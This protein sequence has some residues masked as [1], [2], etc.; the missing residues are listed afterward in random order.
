M[1]VRKSDFDVDYSSDF[2]RNVVLYHNDRSNIAGKT[3]Y[4]A[5]DGVI[6]EEKGKKDEK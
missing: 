2:R 1:I 6:I 5:K 4:F 3:Y